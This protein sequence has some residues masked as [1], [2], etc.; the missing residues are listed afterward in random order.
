MRLFQLVI[1]IGSGF[2]TG[3]MLA[4]PK[5]SRLLSRSGASFRLWL[6]KMKTGDPNCPPHICSAK[7]IYRKIVE[8][9][10]GSDGQSYKDVDNNDGEE[11][12]K[13]DNDN[14]KEDDD[15]SIIGGNAGIR[16]ADDDFLLGDMIGQ[17]G[18]CKCHGNDHPLVPRELFDISDVTAPSIKG[19]RTSAKKK[20]P[21]AGGGGGGGG[22]E[23]QSL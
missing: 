12:N 9:T 6:K 2:R 7:R 15:G 17:G 13:E 22:K 20:W 19:S 14:G 18:Q 8:A 16:I 3:T 5:R 11:D 10:D 23:G 1:Q 21:S 4:I